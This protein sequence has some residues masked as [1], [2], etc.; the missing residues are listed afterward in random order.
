MSDHIG[1]LAFFDDT[2]RLALLHDAVHPWFKRLIGSRRDDAHMGTVTR[3]ADKWSVGIFEWARGELS[4]PED[5]RDGH[6][7][8]KAAFVLGSITHR[9]ADRHTKPITRAFAGHDDRGG[10]ANEAKI[11][12]DL[13][14]FREVYGSGGGEQAGVFTPDLL[15]EA[16]TEPEAAARRWFRVMLRRELIAMHTIRSDA[17]SIHPWLDAFFERLQTFPKSLELYARLNSDWDLAKV[18]RYLVRTRFYDR[19]DAIIALARRAQGGASADH[20]AVVAAMDATDASS[21]WYAR[22]LKR[23]IEYTLAAG[24]IVEGTIDRAEAE[25]RLDIG[26][27]ELALQNDALRAIGAETG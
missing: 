25:R 11:M 14:V 10:Q 13:M 7:E 20:G 15:D 2:A 4:K 23:A 19:D 26:V 8:R 6:L 12:Q 9:A 3:Y 18:D 22:G 16:A 21:S 1:H 17:E 27:P 24:E 5:D